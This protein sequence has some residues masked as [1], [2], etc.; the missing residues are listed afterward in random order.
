MSDF[1]AEAKSEFLYPFFLFSFS[2]GMRAGEITAL[3]WGDIDD[4]NNV[5]HVTKTLS[6]RKGGWV[7]TTPKTRTSI[8][9][10]PINQPIRQ[11]LKLQ[12]ESMLMVFGS[13]SLKMDA[14]VFLLPSGVEFGAPGAFHIIHKVLKRL[15]KKGIHIE[16]FSH[17]ACR[18]TFA[19]QYIKMG[20]NMQTL[21]TILGHSSLA[22]T[23]DLYA[24]VLP[25]TKQQEMKL[26]QDVFMRAAGK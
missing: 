7:E 22:M 1:L 5:I 18:D 19:T 8:R 20:G 17:H 26:I 23:M 11:A 3:T 6:A 4:I 24:H 10:I 25:D 21:K 16:P 13:Q 12:K 2:T 9:D 14:R 15:D